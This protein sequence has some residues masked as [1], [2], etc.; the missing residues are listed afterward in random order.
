MDE[1]FKRVR[2]RYPRPIDSSCVEARC[3]LSPII[4]SQPFYQYNSVV[5]WKNKAEVL[6]IFFWE[7]FT[8]VVMKFCTV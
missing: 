8:V 3:E 5:F 6:Q 7:S 4:N 2:K 1:I